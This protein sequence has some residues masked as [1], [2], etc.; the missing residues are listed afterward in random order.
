MRVGVLCVGTATVTVG[1][2]RYDVTLESE[3]D[4]IGGDFLRPP[5]WQTDVVLDGP[6]ELVAD[7]TLGGLGRARAGRRAHATDR[8]RRDRGCG[9]C[10]TRL[11]RSRSWSSA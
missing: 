5:G 6:T 11:P 8:R 4:D 7:V 3:S 9:R 2:Q 10:G 1:D